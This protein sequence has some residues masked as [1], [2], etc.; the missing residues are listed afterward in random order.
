[1]VLGPPRHPTHKRHKKSRG[2][3]AQPTPQRYD[4]SHNPISRRD[5]REEAPMDPQHQDK[6][7]LIIEDHPFVAQATQILLSNIDKTLTFTIC[8]CAQSAKEELRRFPDWFRIFVDLNIP[9]A[10]GLSL[11]RQIQEFGAANRCAIVTASGNSMWATEAKQMGMIGYIMKTAP[12]DR[13]TAGLKSVLDGQAAFPQL[14]SNT[15]IAGRLTR[16]QQDVLWLLHRGRSTKQ[17]ASQLKLSK[18]TVDN[19]VVNIL[20]ALDASNRTHAICKAME[21]GFLPPQDRCLFH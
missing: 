13:F 21:L 3:V 2:G 5:S 18:G 17:I 10:Y 6:R 11:A 15:Y 14:V 4:V 9:G 19:H 20:R 12:I 8:D 7:V 1:M 16:R